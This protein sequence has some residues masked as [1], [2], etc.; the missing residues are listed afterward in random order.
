MKKGFT[1]AEV[2]ITLGVIGV[3]AAL[4]I[5][6]LNVSTKEKSLEAKQK[7]CVSDLENAFT[8]MIASEG[9]ADLDETKAFTETNG[10][11][12]N[13]QKYIKVYKSSNTKCIM[14]NGAEIEFS[15]NKPYRITNSVDND[16]EKDDYIALCSFDINGTEKPNINNVDQFE[17]ALL[18][19]GLL[20]KIG[21]KIEEGPKKHNPRK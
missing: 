15:T 19:T 18:K 8:T 12:D 4:T 20:E 16:I 10:I 11:V 7:V 6:T 1:L 9:V 17:Y 2:L 21:N 14:K 13:L 3:V 5:P